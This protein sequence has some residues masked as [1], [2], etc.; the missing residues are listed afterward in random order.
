MHLLTCKFDQKNHSITV[1]C[2]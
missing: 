2:S 1:M